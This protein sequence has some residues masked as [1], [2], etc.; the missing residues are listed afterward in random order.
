MGFRQTTGSTSVVHVLTPT[1]R[2]DGSSVHVGEMPSNALRTRLRLVA[3]SQWWSWL[4]WTTLPVD[5]TSG[6]AEIDG[7]QPH[8]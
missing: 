1:T 8:V 7:R 2:S 4:T 6:A 3:V 5:N